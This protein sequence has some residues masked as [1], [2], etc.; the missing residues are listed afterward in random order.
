[1]NA[2]IYINFATSILTFVF[3]V[4]L[5]TGIIYPDNKDSSKVMFGIVLIIYGVYRFINVLSKVKQQKLD[6]RMNKINDER[7]KLLRGSHEK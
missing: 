7:E 4:L 5:L 2:S 6:D 3:G 1:M